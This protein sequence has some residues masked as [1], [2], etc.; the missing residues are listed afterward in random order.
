MEPTNNIPI[1]SSELIWRAMEDGLV[2]VSP[3]EGKVR[4]LN[5]SASTI[6][7]LVDGNRTIGEIA[8]ILSERFE[9]TTDQAFQDVDA[10]LETMVKEGL[11]LWA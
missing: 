9:V 1:L 5:E 8:I 4:V 2:I 6:W 10:F 3:E 7:T 11:V